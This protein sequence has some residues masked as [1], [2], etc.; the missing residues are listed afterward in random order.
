MISSDDH[1][2]IILA[3][4][5]SI[6]ASKYSQRHPMWAFVSPFLGNV[7]R[8]GPTTGG[9]TCHTSVKMTTGGAKSV[10]DDP[11]MTIYSSTVSN[12]SSRC[13]YLVYRKELTHTVH[14]KSPTDLG[15]L[16]SDA[17]LALN[18]LGK[19]PLAVI[20]SNSAANPDEPI[21]ES[22]VICEYIA[23]RFDHVAPSFVP[24]TPELRAKARTIASILDVYIGQLHP[25]MYKKD[26]IGDRLEGVAKMKAGFDAL[27][28]VLDPKGPYATGDMLTTADCC[29]WGNFA[30]YDFMLPTFFGWTATD[31]RPKLAAWRSAMA[32]ESQAARDVYNEVFNGLLGWWDKNRWP[33]MG[34]LPLTPRPT[35]SV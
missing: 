9:A 20:H 24:K 17:Y 10:S 6:A 14:I 8:L 22:A 35:S 29:L 33:A 7:A 11:A 28:H 1:N 2:I 19:I 16:K 23:E 31:G 13:R 4:R 34:V 27:E 25:Y 18:P 26:V 5:S 12:Y 15:G 21:F 30:F 32:V 3:S